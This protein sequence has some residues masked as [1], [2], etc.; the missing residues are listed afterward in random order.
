MLC[1]NTYRLFVGLFIYYNYWINDIDRGFEALIRVTWTSCS[2]AIIMI[3][4]I[5]LNWLDWTVNRNELMTASICVN[6][7]I[8][9]LFPALNIAF[10]SDMTTI[11]KKVGKSRWPWKKIHP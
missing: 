3:A 6:A 10:L 8:I 2:F 5:V 7:E 11:D 1:H 4:V 9:L